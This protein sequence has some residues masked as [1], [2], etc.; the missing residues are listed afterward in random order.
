VIWIL[1]ARLNEVNDVPVYSVE[2][3]RI[4]SYGRI[5]KGYDIHHGSP[6]WRTS[7]PIPSEGNVY[8]PSVKEMEQ[9]PVCTAVSDS[10][11]G[12][13]PIQIGYCNGRNT[14]YNG[15]E[16]HKGSEI[17]VAVTDF[18]LVL[19]HLMRSMICRMMFHR[20][21]YSLSKRVLSLEMYSTT[22]HLSPCR[23]N[24]EGFKDIIVLPRGTNTPLEEEEESR[25]HL[26]T[27]NQIAA[28]AQQMGD[29]TS[30]D[31]SR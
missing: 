30:K 7:T 31:G 18:M 14:T 29:C 11:Y 17:N 27:Q 23:V 1:L 25:K 8:L 9:Q 3:P 13:M 10:L 20:R 4:V 19:G 21:K 5:V 16:Y 12:G 6:I 2:D 22:L 15:F 26:V 24:E 28:A